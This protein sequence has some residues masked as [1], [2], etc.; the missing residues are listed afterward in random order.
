MNKRKTIIAVVCVL[1]VLVLAA[2]GVSYALNPERITCN[3]YAVSDLAMEYWGDENITY[4]EVRSDQVQTVYLSD[5]QQVTEVYVKDGQSV[6]KGDKL[7]SYDT[8]LSALEVSRKEI[9]IK[10]MKEEL[11]AAKK[12]YNNLAGSKVYT[13][14]AG[15]LDSAPV[16]LALEPAEPTYRLTF[17]TNEAA[18]EQTTPEEET[19]VRG[20][21][22]DEEGIVQTYFRFDG[23]GTG[24]QTDPYLYVCAEGI[25]FDTEFLQEIGLL[26][27]EGEEETPP[28]EGE[29]TPEEEEN[30]DPDPVYVV[31][32]ISEGNKLTGKILQAGGMCFTMKDGNISFIVFDASDYIGRG[33]GEPKPEPEP[34]K[35]PE[36]PKE[37]DNNQGGT[38]QGG[39]NQG[40]TNQGGTNQGGTNQ[41][42]TNQGGSNQGGTNQGGTN[43]GGTNQGGTSKP[44]G[45]GSSTSKPNGS[46]SS[47]SKP[48]GSGS[49]STSKPNGSGS[50]SSSGTTTGPSYAEIQAQKAE[51]QQTIKDLDLEL[52]M[53]EVEL[54][55][56]KQEL[57]DGI[58]YAEMAG[59]ISSLQEV[60][61]AYQT[62]EPLLKLAGGGGYYIEGA[63]SELNLGSVHV[64]QSVSVTSWESGNVYEGKIQSI[65]ET[66]N[67]N[68]YFYGSGNPNVSYY[69][70]VV[71]IDSSADLR[72]YESVEMKLE[73][74]QVASEFFYLEQPFIIEEE[75]R[76]YVYV[77]DEEGK[78]EK[79]QI[80]TGATLWGSSIQILDGLTR[81]DAI[82]FPYGKDVKE[83]AKTQIST[84]D[85]LYGW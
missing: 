26:P 22:V 20:P 80:I 73:E 76:S 9:E 6:R 18:P 12:K 47:T 60:E 54:K 16:Q 32:G 77:A 50:S 59:T 45:S 41:G 4:G 29:T 42:G 8:T 79:R 44:N 13:V 53:A 51:L 67:D 3:V 74:E 69:P 81:E 5:T 7:L 56:M 68:G 52:R 23:I 36:P 34:P 27:K 28:A 64:G 78:L 66:P 85:E 30:K 70:F 31:F 24:T 46:G 35:P 10:Q 49:S 84:L 72:E 17:L 57:S 11:T 55:R 33:F 43:Q 62:G 37:E 82:A 61:T 14:A 40:G 83:G 65:S 19:V 25:P 2:V 38:N 48:N 71:S 63:I 15:K 39:T 75:G 1:L 21:S 58:V